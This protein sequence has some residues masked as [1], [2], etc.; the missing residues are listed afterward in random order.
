MSEYRRR[1]PQEM[2]GVERA[3]TIARL[4]RQGWT[5]ARIG[6]VVGLSP[7]GAKYALHGRQ[8]E[9]FEEEVEHVAASPDEW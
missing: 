2:S 6:K 1:Q 4:R 7:N 9:H 5:W 3:D 8:A